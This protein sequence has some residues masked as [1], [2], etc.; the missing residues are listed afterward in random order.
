M[1]IVSLIFIVAGGEC[2]FIIALLVVVLVEVVFVAV[3]AD[4]KI[5]FGNKNNKLTM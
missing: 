5:I 2:I 3:L 1:E 4:L